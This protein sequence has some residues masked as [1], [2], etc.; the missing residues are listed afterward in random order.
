MLVDA[1]CAV[2]GAR[3]CH[4]EGYAMAFAELHDR[5]EF[6]LSPTRRRFWSQAAQDVARYPAMRRSF[7]LPS[8]ASESRRPLPACGP[9]GSPLSPTGSHPSLHVVSTPSE[10]P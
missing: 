4:V 5:F 8:C 9:L 10:H 3:R 7:E 1:S 6:F 2:R